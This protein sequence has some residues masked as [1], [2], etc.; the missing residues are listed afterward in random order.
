MIFPAPSDNPAVPSVCLCLEASADSASACIIKN[1]KFISEAISPA[2][3]GHS[4]TLIGLIEQVIA[5]SQSAPDQI[6]MIIAG[7]GPGSFTGLRVCLA[8]AHGY[9]LATGARAAGVSALVALGAGCLDNNTIQADR[10]ISF[11][12]SRR[13]SLFVQMFDSGLQ[14]LTQI[15]DIRCDDLADWLAGWQ[16]GSP[17]PVLAG[18]TGLLPV[19]VFQAY[20]CYHILTTARLLAGM[21]I[22]DAGYLDRNPQYCLPLTPLYVHPAFVTNK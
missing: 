14:A 3:H 19:P 10:I 18:D 22:S 9:Q 1:G 17:P 15:E 6:D 13:N 21:I 20:P 5:D 2:R 16:A 4:E 7:C 11:C 12:D 8:T